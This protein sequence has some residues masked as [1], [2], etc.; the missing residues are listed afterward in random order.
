M[1]SSSKSLSQLDMLRL[2]TMMLKF[3]LQSLEF[4]L[5]MI[6]DVLD[7]G[8]NS[9]PVVEEQNTDANGEDNN[10][11]HSH[12]PTE[13]ELNTDYSSDEKTPGIYVCL[14]ACKK[15]FVSG[16]RQLVGID[17]YFLKGTFGGQMLVAVALD[18]NDCIYPLA[19]AIVERENTSSWRWF[20][21]HLG[22]DLK[23][24]NCNEW[25]FMSDR[26]KGLQNVID[27]MYPNAEHRF[28]VRHMYTNFFRAEFRELALK[29]II[30]KAAKSTTVA[31][32]LFWMKEMDK[33]SKPAYQWLLKRGPKEWS[34]SHFTTR[35]K[36]DILLNN[37]CECFNKVVLDDREKSIV[38][39]LID[40]HI[41]CMKQIQCRRDKMRRE[42][43]P[44]CPKIHAKLVNNMEMASGSQVDWP[45][46]TQWYVRS[47]D[48]EFVVDIDSRTCTCRKWDLTGIPCG[49]ACAA[50]LEK[51]GQP[52]HYVLD[53][54]KAKLQPRRCQK[55]GS[56]QL[57]EPQ[58]SD[59]S[60]MPTLGIIRPAV[61]AH[62]LDVAVHGPDLQPNVSF[63]NMVE[64]FA[65][66]GT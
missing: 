35:V 54:Y 46:G 59:M 48:G 56:S 42:V 24:A 7:V 17:G 64:G 9:D 44:L 65:T 15:G 51:M 41:S 8:L 20:M 52:I 14:D 31:D 36:S 5:S 66:H 60:F 49:H 29:E 37:L 2:N 38:T 26:Q 6:P 13:E 3:N 61:A 45:G 40:M 19:Y 58:V 33:Q 22:G 34:K 1:Q 27:D 57:N 50:I 39:M 10:S 43:G 11:D 63:D 55:S 53:C 25:T 28:C 18:A 16:C 23:I 4:V 62:G 21:R 47:R 30:W 32:Y 12:D